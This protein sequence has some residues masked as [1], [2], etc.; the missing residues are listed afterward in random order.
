MQKGAPPGRRAP[1]ASWV[2]LRSAPA[3]VAR[4]AGRLM[5]RQSPRDAA[6]PARLS[7]AAGL[8]AALGRRSRRLLRTLRVGFLAR[9]APRLLRGALREDLCLRARRVAPVAGAHD[10]QHN[11]QRPDPHR[12]MVPRSASCRLISADRSASGSCAR[13]WSCGRSTSPS[14]RSRARRSASGTAALASARISPSR[15]TP[16]RSQRGDR[17]PPAPH[18]SRPGRPR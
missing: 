1:A 17:E 6:V 3:A 8:A 9:R 18:R 7:F 15:S 12:T 4:A 13:R 14:W 5:A 2:T 10:Q 16:V 11:Q